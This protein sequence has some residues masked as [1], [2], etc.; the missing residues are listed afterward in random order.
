M[1]SNEPTR[2][3]A[4]SKFA[5]FYADFV[6]RQI[7]KAQT[8]RSADLAAYSFPHYNDPIGSIT[9]AD[10]ERWARSMHE[11][12]LAASTIKTRVS[13]IRAVMYSAVRDGIIPTNPAVGIRLPRSSTRAVTTTMPSETTIA[14]VV[15]AAEGPYKLLIAL[16]AYAG[17][18]L[19]EARALTWDDVDVVA[20]ALY[21]RAQVQQTPGGGWSLQPPKYDSYRT[22]PI[23]DDLKPL[24]EEAQEDDP[25]GL[26]CGADGRPLHPGSVN[27]EWVRQRV[28]SDLPEGFRIHDLRHWY[29]SR[30]IAQ[31][32]NVLTVQRRLGHARAS[33]TLDVYSH[34]F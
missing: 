30:L 32:A 13:S 6:Q 19:G 21:I 25:S 31:G 1:F 22:I 12:G 5:A 8:K 16:A 29:A 15:R 4:R 2:I 28:A 24:L 33:T 26:V 3:D 23:S 17:L 20:D 27:R 14:E 10:I 9:T 34:A 7:W 11:A 18:R